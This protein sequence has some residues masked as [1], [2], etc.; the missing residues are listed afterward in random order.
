[1]STVYCQSRAVQPLFSPIER[2]INFPKQEQLI[3]KGNLVPVPKTMD[4]YPTTLALDLPSQQTVP[5][6]SCI[7]GTQN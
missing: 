5:G 2:L 6:T 3:S 4:F 7:P 1:M